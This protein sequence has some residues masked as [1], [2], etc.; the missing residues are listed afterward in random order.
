MPVLLLLTF[1]SVVLFLARRF[2]ASSLPQDGCPIL[3]RQG[4]GQTGQTGAQKD[5]HFSCLHT[6]KPVSRG[7]FQLCFPPFDFWQFNDIFFWL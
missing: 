1:P 7:S 3:H 5:M 6:N 2:P 4:Q